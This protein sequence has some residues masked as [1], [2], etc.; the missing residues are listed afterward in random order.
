MSSS[1]YI[2]V[3]MNVSS[4]AVVGDV[5]SDDRSC[6]YSMSIKPTL[7]LLSYKVYIVSVN[8]EALPSVTHALLGITLKLLED[9]PTYRRYIYC[10]DIVYEL[11]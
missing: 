9:D 1:E 3:E 5:I 2:L 8:K 6:R 11:V 4:T 7:H 10:R